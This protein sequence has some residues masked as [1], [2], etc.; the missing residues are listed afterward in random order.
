MNRSMHSSQH[1]PNVHDA[2]LDMP[3]VG[4]HCAACANRIER[5]LT[6]TPGVK[7]AGVNF[8]AARATVQFDPGMVTPHD[9]KAAV[10]EQGYDALLPESGGGDMSAEDAASEAQQAEARRVQSRFFVAAGF[11]LPLL[12][13]AMAGHV[14][15]ALER[16]LNFPGRPWVE[17][18]LATPVL[19]WAGW[20]FIL[21]AVRAARHRA[22]DMNTLVALGT[23]S[24][25]LYSLVATVFPEWFI[26]G[27]H[28]GTPSHGHV[29][30]YY[31]VAASIVTLILLGNMLQARA[32]TRT[33]G[34]IRALM[35]LRPK[36][37]RVVRDGQEQDV[38]I[39]GVTVGDLV[40]VRPGEKVPVD[41]HVVEGSSNI[42]E[43]M[44]TGEP[45]P[46]A[47][48]HDDMVIGGTLNTTGSF[49]FRAT[50]VGSDTVL[51]QIVRLVQQAQ[52]SKAPIQRLA[53]KISGVFVPVV[54]SLA[55]LTF[56]AWFDFAPIG[57]RLSQA[58]LA[59]VS[60]LIIACPCALGLATPTAIMVGTGRGAQGGILIKG[61]QALE[62]AQRITTVVLDKT[63]TV[64]EGKPTVTDIVPAESIAQ[65]QLLR[66]AASAERASEHPLGAAIVRTATERGLSLATAVDFEAI[67]GHGLQTTVDGRRVLIGNA[68]L[69]H[70]RGL[71]P[72]VTAAQAMNDEGKT[73]VFVAL[74][75]SYAGFIAVADRV[76]PEAKA[77]IARLR[78]LGLNVVL[79]TGDTQRTAQAVARQVGIERVMAD[80]LPAG[81]AD[82]VRVLQGEGHTVAMVGDGINDAPALAQ[83][84]VGIAMGGGTD[85]AIEASDITLVRGDLHG[86]PAAIALSQATMRTVR[87]NLF[88]AFAYNVIGIPIA[89]G[90]LVPFT[91]WMLSP[92]LASLAMALSS[93]S[94][95]TNALRLRGFSIHQG[96]R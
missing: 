6:E 93:I 54:L 11:T 67:A 15:P 81:K 7:Q 60:V 48:K 9:L 12:I 4:M 28:D 14:I 25:Y 92:I 75:G 69:L 80:V 63:G 19:F 71:N 38:A 22:A 95:V 21:G 96:T 66:L 34:A 70:E 42:D 62:L 65:D 39:E 72:D 41:G 16:M 87:Q 58:T 24:A 18:L 5:A 49:T 53:D 74:D 84:D 47:K 2:S 35:G 3:V 50:K 26:V 88:F 78:S 29:P 85:V 27:D 64:T 56:V 51:Q 30:V 86:V 33:R 32:T 73:L 20:E 40:I 45:L 79:L 83:A 91:G 94:V 10:Q 36:T 43:S 55:V 23:L 46:V 8:A 68:K 13:I 44:L 57:T 82:A 89:A 77:A 90:V 61:G 59:A 1:E 52:G 17:L 31:E 76:K 37:A